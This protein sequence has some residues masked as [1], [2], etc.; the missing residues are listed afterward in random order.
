MTPNQIAVVGEIS[1]H[2]QPGCEHGRMPLIVDRAGKL[3]QPQAGLAAQ[4]CAAQAGGQMGF[5]GQRVK[6]AG[7]QEQARASGRGLRGAG[8]RN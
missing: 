3:H 2:F 6:G 1:Y 7:A 4:R 5:A 8:R